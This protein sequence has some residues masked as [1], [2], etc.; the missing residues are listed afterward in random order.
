M[1]EDHSYHDHH[2]HTHS[3][4]REWQEGWL[5]KFSGNPLLDWLL[6]PADAVS[7][8][9]E[10]LYQEMLAKLG[11]GVDERHEDHFNRLQNSE[12]NLLDIADGEDPFTSL[13]QVH[14]HHHSLHCNHGLHGH[15]EDSGDSHHHCSHDHS[16]LH[17]HAAGYG[18][19][20]LV[21]LAGLATAGG[22]VVDK[23]KN[24]PWL[25]RVPLAAVAA[26]PLA[27]ALI[28][29]TLSEMWEHRKKEGK[30][31]H[32]E[33]LATHG[34]SAMALFI[35]IVRSDARMMSSGILLSFLMGISN[36]TQGSVISTIEQENNAIRDRILEAANQHHIHEGM[37]ITILPGELIPCDGILTSGTVVVDAVIATGQQEV[38]YQGEPLYQGY[39]NQTKQPITMRVTKEPDA[40]HYWT[41]LAASEEELKEQGEPDRTTSVQ[42]HINNWYIPLMFVG[43]LGQFSWSMTKEA[44]GILKHG[45]QQMRETHTWNPFKIEWKHNGRTLS[46]AASVIFNETLEAAIVTSPCTLLVAGTVGNFVRRLLPREGIHV[47]NPN[48]FEQLGEVDTVF[49]DITGTLTKAIQKVTVHG[50]ENDGL[51]HR[52][53]ALEEIAQTTH[54]IGKSIIAAGYQANYDQKKHAVTATDDSKA[55]G[56]SGTVDGYKLAIGNADYIESYLQKYG[57]RAEPGFAVARQQSATLP[58]SQAPLFCFQEAPDGTYK[59]SLLS[60]D[61]QLRST[62]QQ[63]IAELEQRGIPKERVHLVTG[64]D[65]VTAQTICNSLGL[66]DENMAHSLNADEKRAYVKSQQ[67]K[68]TLYIGDGANDGLA[69]QEAD[70]A[71]SIGAHT[72]HGDFQPHISISNLEQMVYLIDIATDTKKATQ[73]METGAIASI[74][75]LTGRHIYQQTKK[76]NTD[77]GDSPAEESFLHEGATALVVAGAYPLAKR[78]IAEGT[79][80]F[81]E[82]TVVS[83]ELRQQ[84]IV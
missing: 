52:L 69:M 46:E 32:L 53:T 57:D 45:F 58:P 2:D 59:V 12:I 64:S 70:I 84:Q 38:Y 27:N 21:A 6:R 17:V 13:R 5:H 83:P 16:G 77:H 75:G 71:L 51:L 63:V 61:Y 49:M 10:A 47:Y 14:L 80:T 43:V 25:A 37:E 54:P 34:L 44:G 65:E 40:S 20:D 48:K 3:G 72:M 42:R 66:S 39:V 81:T 55:N 36:E 68:R 60:V 1:T 23:F 33:H 8:Q 4:R 29:P 79:K 76:T 62:A 19:D 26:A 73:R 15:D 41:R 78:I 67:G 24:W 30:W 7:Q 50:E 31:S 56:I 28:R 9:Y 82:R 18:V 11:V 35:G 22:V 74:A